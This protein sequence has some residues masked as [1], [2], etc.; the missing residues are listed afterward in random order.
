[1][2]S[3]TVRDIGNPHPTCEDA[4]IAEYIE[5]RC[6][7]AE[8]DLDLRIHTNDTLEGKTAHE[9]FL[10]PPQVNMALMLEG[11]LDA[12][13]NGQPLY[14]TSQNGPAGYLWIN[15]QSANLDRW[16][17]SGQRVRKVAISLPWAQFAQLTGDGD[18]F[19]HFGRQELVILRWQP[20][21]QALR[22]AEDILSSEPEA[23]LLGKLNNGLAALG[24]LY[25]AL[26]QNKSIPHQAIP[27]KLNTRDVKRAWQLRDYVLEH[28]H[29]VLTVDILA[30]KTGMSISTLQRVF[31]NTYGATVMDFIRTRRL[32]LARLAILE[33]GLTAGQ[34]AH[35]AGYSSVANFSTAFQRKFGYPP[36]ACIRNSN[37]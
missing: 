1:M 25:Q 34:A 17:R 19:Q 29:N 5:G 36:S 12:A 16:I 30:K 14:M 6:T 28:I 3:L 24:L 31:K 4:S 37:N 18:I 27:I 13:V 10:I 11:D 32:E 26:E 22:F 20:N 8:L 35:D 21:A 7:F 2:K 9:Q 23:M 15:R 33:H